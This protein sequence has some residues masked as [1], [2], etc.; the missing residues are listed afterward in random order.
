MRK[1]Y[2]LVGAALIALAAGNL[3]ASD[4]SRTT[5]GIYQNELDWVLAP[6]EHFNELTHDYLIGAFDNLVGT[7]GYYKAGKLPLSLGTSLTGSKDADVTSQELSPSETDTYE[8]PLFDYWDLDFF[9]TVGLKEINN[10]S[11]GVFLNMKGTDKGYSYLPA[12]GDDV[13]L[14]D[15]TSQIN[16]TVPFGMSFGKAYNLASVT[17]HFFSRKYDNSSA[18]NDDYSKEEISYSASDRLTMPSV[19]PGGT[20]TQIWVGAELP[21]TESYTP[22]GSVMKSAYYAGV[23]NRFDRN[24][25]KT[26]TLALYPGVS[27]DYSLTDNSAAEEKLTK[28]NFKVFCSAAVTV[29]FPGTPFALYAGSEPYVYF[30]TTTT[31]DS[32]GGLVI[33]ER[34]HTFGTALYRYAVGG[35]TLTLPEDVKIDFTMVS[36]SNFTLEC[37]IPFK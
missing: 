4:L 10:L 19:I 9:G 7:I 14:V 32:A 12:A 22:A 24:I 5:M 11:V 1:S 34:G 25:G 3:G 23:K 27:A 2:A 31:E 20:E 36:G 6:N 18:E 37:V 16:L 33:E 8:Y 35:L 30:T 13:T 21:R 15:S 29:R 28:M 17:A 26:F